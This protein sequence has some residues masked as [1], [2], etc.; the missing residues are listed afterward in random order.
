MGVRM[1]VAESTGRVRVRRA[2]EILGLSPFSV[3]DPRF[4]RKHAIPASRIGR[5]VV[6]DVGELEAYLQRRREDADGRRVL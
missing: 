5:A 4:R 3:A 6:F 2:A 1:K